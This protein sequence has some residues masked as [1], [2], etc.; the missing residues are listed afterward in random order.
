MLAPAI[1]NARN[2]HVLS[3]PAETGVETGG[4]NVP[5]GRFVDINSSAKAFYPLSQ[6]KPTDTMTQKAMYF[7]DDTLLDDTMDLKYGD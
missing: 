5:N 7:D 4:S 3:S 6:V 2:L 1:H